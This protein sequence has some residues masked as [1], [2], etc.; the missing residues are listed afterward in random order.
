MHA[1][2][3]FGESPLIERGVGLLGSESMDNLA[4]RPDAQKAILGGM[5]QLFPLPKSTLLRGCRGVGRWVG[6]ISGLVSGKDYRL[7]RSAPSEN[8][9]VFDFCEGFGSRNRFDGSIQEGEN[10]AFCTFMKEIMEER[11]SSGQSE[12]RKMQGKLS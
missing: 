1:S 9:G 12:T 6:S 4:Y 11:S 10:I 5:R 8:G 3:T 7:F 2:G